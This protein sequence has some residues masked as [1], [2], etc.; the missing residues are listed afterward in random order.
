MKIPEAKAVV[1]KEWNKLMMLPV[2]QPAK[3]TEGLFILHLLRI[4]AT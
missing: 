2:V 1:D 4:F 3:R